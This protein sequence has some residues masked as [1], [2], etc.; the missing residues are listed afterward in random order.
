VPIGGS[1]V[2]APRPA[3]GGFLVERRVAVRADHLTSITLGRFLCGNIGGYSGHD[4][5]TPRLPESN[6]LGEGFRGG[7]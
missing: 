2:P 4:P 6:A 7:L 3:V 1:V 5:M